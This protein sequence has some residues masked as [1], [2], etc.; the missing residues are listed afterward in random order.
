[1]REYVEK[2][3]PAESP[4]MYG[5]HPNAQLQLLNAQCDWLFKTILEVRA[6]LCLHHA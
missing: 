1:M 4:V 3:L 2:S 6:A 5:L